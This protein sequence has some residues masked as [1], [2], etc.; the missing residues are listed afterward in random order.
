MSRLYH[1]VTFAVHDSEKEQLDDLIHELQGLA[2][3][4]M[5]TRLACGRNCTASE[6]DAALVVE[7]AGEAELE[8]YRAHPKHVPVAARLRRLSRLLAVADFNA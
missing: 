7:L 4:P 5:V 2:A 3:L 6:Y 8:A 1:V